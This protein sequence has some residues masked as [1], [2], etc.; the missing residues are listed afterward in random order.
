MLFSVRLSFFWL[1][2]PEFQEFD[3]QITFRTIFTE[4]FP[5]QHVALKSFDTVC[6]HISPRIALFVG[7]LLTFDAIVGDF[8][9]KNSYR[10]FKFAGI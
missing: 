7:L 5:N 1:Y 4:S 3:A 2:L 10:F 6:R 8:I 9:S